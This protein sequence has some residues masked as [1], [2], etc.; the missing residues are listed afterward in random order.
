M[1]LCAADVFF[2]VS[3]VRGVLNTFT[4]IEYIEQRG[5]ASI[6]NPS[7]MLCEKNIQPVKTD[8]HIVFFSCRNY[9][10]DT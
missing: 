2:P 6:G 9:H 8:F 5:W 7:S 10:S 4:Y 3:N 1:G